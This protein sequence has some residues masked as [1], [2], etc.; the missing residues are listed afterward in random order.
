M[1]ISEVTPTI[2][3]NATHGS[4]ETSKPVVTIAPTNRGEKFQEA[5]QL[6]DMLKDLVNEDWKPW[7]CKHFHRLGRERTLILAAQARVD[8]FDKRKLFSHLL[9][10]N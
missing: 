9:K 7:Y 8:G 2:V 10:E 6:F 1:H 4:N 5:D 3:T